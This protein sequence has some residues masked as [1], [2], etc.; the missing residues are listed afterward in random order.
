MI[1]GWRAE[2]GICAEHPA[3]QV[4]GGRGGHGAVERRTRLPERLEE[5]RRDEQEEKRRLERELTVEQ[6]QADAH[7]DDGDGKRR[8]ELEGERGDEREL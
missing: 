1:C 6:A 2:G 4:F 8:D 7:G 5:L 3:Q